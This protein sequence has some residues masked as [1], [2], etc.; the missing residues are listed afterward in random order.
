MKDPHGRRQTA[1]RWCLVAGCGCWLRHGLGLTPHRHPRAPPRIPL[2][3]LHRSQSTASPMTHRS[4]PQTA[5]R[6]VSVMT[7]CC[8]PHHDGPRRRARRPFRWPCAR[9][10]THYRPPCRTINRACAAGGV[11]CQPRM[12]PLA[13]SSTHP[14]LPTGLGTAPVWRAMGLPI[15]WSHLDQSVALMLP[16]PPAAALIAAVRPSVYRV[17]PS[18]FMVSPQ[19]RIATPSVVSC[20]HSNLGT[21][22]GP[23]QRDAKPLTHAG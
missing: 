3:S 7:C 10:P 6:A 17:P 23:Q 13:S 5:T 14:L 4:L 15:P 16:P 21:C 9:A 1:Q 8:S 12:L 19:R 22:H 11:R 2:C 20:C 18:S